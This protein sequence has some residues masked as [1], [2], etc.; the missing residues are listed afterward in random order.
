MY[1]PTYGFSG[2]HHRTKGLPEQQDEE[3]R[4]KKGKRRALAR[5]PIKN[6]L[7]TTWRT[8]KPNGGGREGENGERGAPH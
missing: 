7:S 2:N 3:E 4:K 6:P 1:L 8:K 5:C